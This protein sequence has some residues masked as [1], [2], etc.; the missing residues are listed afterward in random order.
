M[1]RVALLIC[2][3]LLALPAN[4]QCPNYP[5]RPVMSSH[6]PPPVSADAISG[7]AKNYVRLAVTLDASGVP[8]DVAVAESSGS[9]KVDE[10]V[11]SHVLTNWRWSPPTQNCQAYGVTTRVGVSLH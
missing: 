10:I 6:T 7:L 2:L 11:R 3:A 8:T 9:S 1:N 5:L 4:A